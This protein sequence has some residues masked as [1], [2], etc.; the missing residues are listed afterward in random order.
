M[1]L[2]PK[3]GLKD[4]SSSWT[5]AT[6]LRA[7]SSRTGRRSRSRR[8]CPTS[9]R[10][11]SSRRSTP[12]PAP[13]CGC[14][15]AAPAQGLRDN[16]ADLSS[17]LRRF[18]PTSRD[19]AKITSQLKERRV[20]IRRTVHNFQLLANALGDK[21][22]AA[23]PA[24]RLHRRGL[25]R[26]RHPRT[27]TSSADA[28]AAAADADATTQSRSR[29]VD[30]ARQHARPDAAGAATRRPRARPVAGRR[31][32]R[33]CARPRR[34]SGTSSGPFTRR[35]PAHGPGAAA[36]GAATWRR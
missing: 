4:M 35:R 21:D 30:H 25:P 23:R 29:K 12:T 32:A 20:N 36:G 1:L 14:C 9:T 28:R 34:S 26:L 16:T 22:D 33:S 11:R 5:R 13:T 19:L 7:R 27:R 8:R 18:E 17:T 24:R 3:T 15:S 10:T 31:P 6:L 2:R